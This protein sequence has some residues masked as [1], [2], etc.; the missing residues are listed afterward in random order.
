M[1]LLP[2]TGL[3]IVG[4][5]I[6][7]NGNF[8]SIY[9]CREI[10]LYSITVHDVYNVNNTTTYLLCMQVWSSNHTVLPLIVQSLI[11]VL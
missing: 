7:E 4:L 2:H 1:T 8:T 6:F 5:N 3:F 9:P 10:L 11:A